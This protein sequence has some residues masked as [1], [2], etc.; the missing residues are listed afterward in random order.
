MQ[1]FS[2]SYRK[3][4]CKSK[5]FYSRTI[6]TLFGKVTYKEKYFD[7]FVRAEICNESSSS[8][9]SKAGKIVSQKI[10]KRIDNNL[11]INRDAG[12]NIVMTFRIP[13]NDITE[14]ELKQLLKLRLLKINGK[15]IQRH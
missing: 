12:R 4:F 2:T 10:E 1:F 7:P 14:N 5:G 6:M 15:A 3:S 8:S 11:N 9:Y 13:D